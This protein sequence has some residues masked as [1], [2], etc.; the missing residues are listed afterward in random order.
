ML[1]STTIVL[2]A[3]SSENKTVVHAYPVLIFFDLELYNALNFNRIDV[4]DFSDFCESETTDEGV[5]GTFQWNKTVVNATAVTSCFY[6]P[7][8]VVATRQCVSRLTWATP[9][10]DRCKTIVSEGFNSLKQVNS[11][12]IIELQSLLIT[13]ECQ[14]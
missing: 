7:D 11:V 9:V 3:K 10:V 13:G 2:S 14:C 4:I 12:S 1:F 8:G 6:G 5:R